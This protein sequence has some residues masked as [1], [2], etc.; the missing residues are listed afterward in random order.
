MKDRLKKIVPHLAAV[1][2]FLGLT[3]T[4]FAPAVFDNKDLIQGDL[5][6]AGGWG[7]DLA[8]YH[9]QTGDYAFW[10]NAMFGGM[11]ANY[12][13]MPPMYNIFAHVCRL[14][15]LDLPGYHVGLV[16]IYL[17][18][19]YIFLVSLGCKPWLSIV[20]AIAY[21]FV[22]YNLI[23]IGA[24]HM[25]K[26]LVMAT[27][28]PIIGGIILCYRKKYLWGIIVTLLFTGMNV[29]WS[30]QQ[31]S[32]YLLITIVVLAIVYLI[33]AIRERTLKD[34]FKSSVL[35][36]VVAFLAI[37]PALG[38][39]L[40]TADYTKETMRGGAVLQNNA[41]GEK[42][43]SGLD[44][45]YAYAWSYGRSETMTLLI[46]NFLGSSSH[47]DIGTK[48]EC[49]SVLRPTG[50]A[51]QFCKYAPM[52]W[53]DQPFTAGPVYAG[54][55]VCFLFLLGIII[56]KGPE[57]WWLLVATIIS[58]IM[59]WGRHFPLVNEFLFYHLPLYN[60]FRAPSMSL[61]IAGITMAALAVLALK[62]FLEKPNKEKYLRALYIATGITG[63]LCLFFAL[64]GGNL[65]SFSAPAD[66]NY[67]NFPELVAALV[68]DRKQMLA[69]D[70]W[71]SFFFIALAAGTL[72]F[73]LRKPFK[74]AYLA[75][76]FGGLIF[77]D[78]WTVDKR[79][80]NHDSFVPKKKAKEIVATPADQ[81]ILQDKDPNYRV[82]NLTKNPFNESETS[83]FHKSV[84]GYSPA[85]LRRYQD[86]I[87]YHLSQSIN[88][89]V[90]NMLNTRYVIA[91]SEQGPQVQINGE[92]LGNVWFVNKLQWVNSPDEEIVALKDFDPAQTA[93]IDI[94]WKENLPA[95]ETLQHETDS[96]A[97]IR[98]A[99]YANPGYLIYESNS[100]QPRLAVFSEVFYKTWHA[101][102]DGVEAPLVRVN[103][104]L[105][106]L[107]V[108]AGNH[109]IEFKCIDDMYYKG[110]RLSLVASYTVAIILLGLFGY[111]IWD[112]LK[113]ERGRL[114]KKKA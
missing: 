97:V 64:F 86:I 98:L 41:Q 51:A 110:A 66:A 93:I 2:L 37:A 81:Q 16:Y 90:L 17:L 94:V 59:A 58:V 102:I 79:F 50:Q 104:I 44:I 53:G 36:L 26:G 43:S 31:I 52:Y 100:E 34:Y 112:T 61:V 56:V 96:N 14:F 77:I 25:N 4:Y 6:S 45:D 101:Y 87:D 62:T 83:Y 47:Y 30:H 20:G 95:W 19:F 21:A 42:T 65:M 114:K 68:A 27:M 24:G 3:I 76:I 108:P 91:P 113:K 88:K 92:A 57:K 82:F 99:D 12:T 39:L 71:R 22:S 1:L 80:I 7:K 32:Y 8:D 109:K 5:T 105:R 33:Y 38:P 48:S 85:K 111:I 73:Y 70:A 60:K 49:Y 74:I 15:I 10:S 46:P 106:G 18:G 55:I 103:Y 67:K 28:A 84:G 9:Q 13:Y 54:A 107:A 69:S 75:I 23:I 72:W 40:T 63:G 78:L 11:P 29:V 89:N 35:L